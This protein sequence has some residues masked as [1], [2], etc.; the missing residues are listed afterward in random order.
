MDKIV[1]IG[2]LF[3]ATGIIAFG[4]QQFIFG[5]FVPGRAPAWPASMPGRLAW[6]YAS[7]T[8]LIIAGLAIIAGKKARWAA[9]VSGTLIFFW[10]LLRHIPVVAAAPALGGEWTSMGKALAL[11]SGAFAVAAASPAEPGRRPGAFSAFVNADSGF[12]Y[13]G[14]CGLGLFMILAGIQH[15]L[16]V[17]FVASLVPTWIPGAVFWTYFA[18]V[19]LIA[20]GAGLLFPP[21][22]R[23]AAALSGLMIFLWVVLLHIPRA[24]AA[25]PAQLR[26]E[27]TAVFEALAMSGIAFVLARPLP[28]TANA[29]ARSFAPLSEN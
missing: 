28:Q 26:N 5:D 7:G 14:R 8:I 19:A 25:P 24:V 2:R 1:P 15:F 11:F 29:P 27:W 13:L 16:F 20:G 4:I 9:I 6:A 17:E 12:T 22:A 18:G 10:A 21:T 23:L 3:F